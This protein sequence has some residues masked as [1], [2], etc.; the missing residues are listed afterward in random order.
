MVGLRD[1]T[2]L[3]VFRG[4]APHLGRGGRLDGPEDDRNPALG[5]LQ[6]GT[7]ALAFATLSGY[8]ADGVCLMR[9]QDGG[10][11]WTKPEKAEATSGLH[12]GRSFADPRGWQ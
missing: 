8:E 2:L 4:G 10:K 6:D 9:S 1:G 7:V 11:T 12:L 3:S 5:Q